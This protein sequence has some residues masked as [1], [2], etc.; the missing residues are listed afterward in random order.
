MVAAE[1]HEALSLR[2]LAKQFGVTAPA[3]YAHV[4]TKQELLGA[5][6]ADGF[7]ELKQRIDALDD[8][9][10]SD[11][12]RSISRAYVAFARDNSELWRLMNLYPADLRSTD[13]S[14][15]ES[16]GGQAFS[17]AARSVFDAMAC[18]EM[19]L[20]DP[21][22]TAVA[23]RSAIHGLTQAY[24]TGSNL[25]IDEE[26]AVLDIVVESMLR[27]LAPVTEPRCP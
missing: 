18:G 17:A 5:V 26:A 9:S 6:A 2:R 14:A 3:L 25:S 10:P 15:S 7:G 11:R 1:G 21:W 12:I 22:L 13:G 24:L 4:E 23:F 27:G 8:P 20:G 19:Q 16:A